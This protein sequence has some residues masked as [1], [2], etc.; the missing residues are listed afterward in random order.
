MEIYNKD[1]K[2]MRLVADIL[3]HPE[4]QKMKDIVHHGMNRYEHCVRV[5]YFSYKLCKMLHLEYEKVAR[6]GL[7][8]D[9]FFEDNEAI[10]SKKERAEI[11]VKHPQYALENAEKYFTLSDL[12]KD[13]ILTHMFPVAPM[14]PKYMESWIVDFIDDLVS[15]Y[16]K[17]F[18]VKRELS[19]AMSFLMIVSMNFLR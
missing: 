5:S 11:M 15:V 18:S 9:F 19:A 14:V 17:S 4:F 1:R 6:A 13:I 8:H 16:E 3:Y 12:E 7:L 10:D 2:Y